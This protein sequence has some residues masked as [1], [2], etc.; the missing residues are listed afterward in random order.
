MVI[1]ITDPDYISEKLINDD[2]QIRRSTVDFDIPLFTN[3][4][5]AKLFIQAL[6][7][8]S[9]DDLKITSYEDYLQKG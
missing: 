6:V 3:L 8:K 7:L 4:Q 9:K 2:Y 5:T 1:N